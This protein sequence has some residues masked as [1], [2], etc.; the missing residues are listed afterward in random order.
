MKRP[1]TRIKEIEGGRIELA[2]LLDQ[3]AELDAN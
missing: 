3:R 2:H 1:H